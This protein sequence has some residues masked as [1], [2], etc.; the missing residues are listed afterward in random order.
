MRP[1]F[2]IAQ[3]VMIRHRYYHNAP[4]CKAD[5]ALKRAYRW[6]N[7]YRIA[8]KQGQIYG[9]T[10]LITMERIAKA[11]N[12]TPDDHVIEMG[13]GR[14]R[15]ALFLHHFFGAKVTGIECIPEF[16]HL[17]EGIVD[18]IVLGD[19]FTV[20]FSKATIVY[21]YGTCLPDEEVERL[22]FPPNVTIVSVSY[23]LPGYYYTSFTGVFPWEKPIFLSIITP[24]SEKIYSLQRRGFYRQ[25][26]NY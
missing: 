2:D 17:S 25:F 10:P 11:C 16:V 9:E 22:V 20:D 21:L 8:R 6:K 23:P 3:E 26:A 5:R 19:M 13:C 18:G 14:G 24:M 15:A 12:I 1:F 4:F 7:P